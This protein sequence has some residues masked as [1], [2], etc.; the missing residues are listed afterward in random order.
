MRRDE[1]TRLLPFSTMRIGTMVHIPAS[2][3]IARVRMRFRERE[4]C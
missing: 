1:H 4:R 3:P 2:L